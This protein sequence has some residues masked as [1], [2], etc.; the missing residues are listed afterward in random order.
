[1]NR[2]REGE[3]S[4]GHERGEGKIGKDDCNFV[5]VPGHV[6]KEIQQAIQTAA[7]EHGAIAEGK[8]TLQEELRQAL[9]RIEDLERGREIW[10][11]DV[12]PNAMRDQTGQVFINDGAPRLTSD[13]GGGTIDVTQQNSRTHDQKGNDSTECPRK[14]R[15]EES[16]LH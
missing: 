1:M 6:W 10:S 9:V 8:R 3:K 7:K 2:P 5:K 14:N 16:R 13:E 15:A 4:N 12:T 11:A